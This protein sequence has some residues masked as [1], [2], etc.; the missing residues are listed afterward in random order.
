MHDQTEDTNA[1]QPLWPCVL[2]MQVGAVAWV[3]IYFFIPET[4]GKT[5][6]EIEELLI[7]KHDVKLRKPMSHIPDV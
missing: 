5:L 7:K 6:E 2:R 3:V 4:K 1:G